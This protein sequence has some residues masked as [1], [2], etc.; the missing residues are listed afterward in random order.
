MSLHLERYFEK[1]RLYID[2]VLC[3]EETSQATLPAI[4][5]AAFQIG[6]DGTDS[7]LD[8]VIDNLR[9]SNIA[10]TSQE[11]STRMTS[12]ISVTSW[13]LSPVVASIELTV[14]WK[15]SQ[16]LTINAVTNVGSRV[17]PMIAATWTSSNPSGGSCRF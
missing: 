16:L 2:G 7:Y 10:R 17:L 3:S 13:N 11:I 4:D 8:G 5:D 9:L 1:L 15:Y 14:G 12:V 6:R